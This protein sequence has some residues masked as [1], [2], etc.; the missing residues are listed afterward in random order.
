VKII[1]TVFCLCAVLFSCTTHQNSIAPNDDLTPYTEN[2]TQNLNLSE[3]A[4][5]ITTS[6]EHGIKQKS[7]HELHRTGEY[8]T[9]AEMDEFKTQ[10]LSWQAA[11]AGIPSFAN[12]IVLEMQNDPNQ[13]VYITVDSFM[14]YLFMPYTDRMMTYERIQIQVPD[15]VQARIIGVFPSAGSGETNIAYYFTEND[16]KWIEVFYAFGGS[17]IEDENAQWQN[18]TENYFNGADD[19]VNTQFFEDNGQ[20]W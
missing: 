10:A 6:G 12:V 14:P 17:L 20:F 3:D 2:E 8:L 1:V 7:L 19:D 4:E 9:Y 18:V 15:G 5:D 13:Q 16:S 11:R